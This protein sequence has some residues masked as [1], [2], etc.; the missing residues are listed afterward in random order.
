MQWPICRRTRRSCFRW[1]RWN[2]TA[3]TCR[4][5]PTACCWAKSCAEP[6]ERLRAAGRVRSAHVAGQL[7]SS[8]RFCRHALGRSAHVSRPAGRPVGELHLS[9]LP[10]PADHQRSRRQHRARPAGGV[11]NPA[12]ISR[13]ATIC[14]CCLPRTG[15]WAPKPHEVDPAIKQQRM[16][17]ACEWETSMMLRLAPHLVGQ[18]PAGGSRALGA[19]RSSRPR[20]AGS[21]ASG[22]GPATSATR[23][24][25]RPKKAKCSSRAFSDDLVSLIERM[26]AWDGKSWD[27]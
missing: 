4:C 21:R 10:P 3:G 14:C 15:C 26:I 27:G 12:A 2:S 24:A 19:N 7:G 23:A 22:R 8:P 17:H 11:R 20:G 13:S 9:R 18:S 1:R 16:G 25:P 6:A 5:L